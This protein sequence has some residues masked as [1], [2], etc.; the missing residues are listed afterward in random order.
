MRIEMPIGHVDTNTHSIQPLV[1]D[2]YIQKVL[3]PLSSEMFKK[4]TEK[5]AKLMAAIAGAE[6]GQ[7]QGPGSAVPETKEQRRLRKRREG[8]ALKAQKEQSKETTLQ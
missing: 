8:L 6:P 4:N 2:H 3:I 1:S 5:M 7:G